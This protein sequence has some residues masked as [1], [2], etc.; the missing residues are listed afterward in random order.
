MA[1][2]QLQIKNVMAT[3]QAL[4][5]KERVEYAS[6]RFKRLLPRARTSLLSS[7]AGSK[8]VAYSSTL[9]YADMSAAQAFAMKEEADTFSTRT[10]DCEG[11]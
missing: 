10:K 4:A 6:L 9:S 11:E 1:Y 5:K 3:A 2:N 7:T 8:R